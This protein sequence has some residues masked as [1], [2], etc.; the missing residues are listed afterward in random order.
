VL[1]VITGAATGIGQAF[2]I[3]RAAHGADVV[4]AD[5]NSVDETIAGFEKAGG[6]TLPSV[7]RTCEC[8]TAP[9]L[10]RSIGRFVEGL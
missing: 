3:A 1:I 6:R 7:P 8:C 4:V 5:M 10:I 2:A 9:S